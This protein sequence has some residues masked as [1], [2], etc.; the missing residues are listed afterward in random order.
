MVWDLPTRVFHWLFVAAIAGAFITGR[1]GDLFWH[2]IF[3]LAALGLFVF[4]IIWGLVGHKTARF[5]TFLAGPRRIWNYLKS[6]LHRRNAPTL[7]HNPLGALSVLALL[8]LMGSLAITGLWTGDDILYEGPLTPLAPDWA[9]P[10]GRWHVILQDLI[11][12]L[13]GLHILALAVHHFILKE[14]LVQRMIHGGE[15]ADTPPTTRRTRIGLCAL[16]VCLTAAIS[17][18]ALTPNY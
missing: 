10:A 3:G 16:V 9:T 13:V 15:G 17:L 14:R 18:A 2:E 11:L 8:G 4:R 1:Q 7:G 12:P 6:L 5:S